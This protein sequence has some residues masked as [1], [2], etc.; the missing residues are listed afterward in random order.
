MENEKPK[1]FRFR[2]RTLLTLIAVIALLVVGAFQQVQINRMQLRLQESRRLLVNEVKTRDQLTTILREQ[3][4]K[5][6]RQKR[7]GN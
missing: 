1:I 7:D 2:I 3:R 4:D 5:I 6:E